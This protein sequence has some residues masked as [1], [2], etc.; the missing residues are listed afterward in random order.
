[1]ERRVNEPI[2]T[3]AKLLDV[4]LLGKPINVIREKLTSLISASCGSLTSELQNWLKTNQVEVQ[5][6]SVELHTFSPSE[7]DKSS[8]SVL[9]HKNGG[10][11]F[12]Y[13]ESNLLIKLADRFY[14]ASIE[15]DSQTLTNS[16]L[17]LQERIS[18]HISHWLAPQDMWSIADFKPSMGIGILAVLNIKING[19]QSTLHFKLDSHL[20][21]TLI[22][23]LE[24]PSPENLY[25]PFCQSLESIPVR[26]NA[27]LSKKQMVLSDVLNFQPNDILPIELLSTVP[28]S[29]GN[30]PLFSGRIAEQDGQLVLILNYDKESQR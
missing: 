28:V 1:M 22:E 16:D 19:Y 14:G 17:R 30:Q 20:V 29:I 15:R 18:K 23:Q 9:R 13:I 3:D 21:Q 26:L 25:Q 6:N 10:T 27:L 8:T 12:V 7:M 11:S 5:P 2:F 4:E 24:L